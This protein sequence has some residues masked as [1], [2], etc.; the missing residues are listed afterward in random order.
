[1]AEVLGWNELFSELGTFLQSLERQLGL[2]NK[3][4]TEYAI[5]RLS[6]CLTSVSYV[7]NVFSVELEGGSDDTTLKQFESMCSELHE[8][9]SHLLLVWR[10]YEENITCDTHETQ[11]RAPIL[12]SG[13]RGR[14][15]FI[16][17]KEQLIYLRSASFSWS[18]I[19][20]LLGVSRI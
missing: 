3:S 17:Q 7:R 5:E 1:M 10:E 11:Y 13:R 12:H 16:I 18:S 8:I 14:P 6:V 4:F 15:S 9:L 2:A 20:I 19:S